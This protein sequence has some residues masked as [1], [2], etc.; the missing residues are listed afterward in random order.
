MKFAHFLSFLM[1]LCSG[2]FAQLPVSTPE[3]DLSVVEDLYLAKD[4]GNGKPGDVVDGFNTYD[5]PIHCVVNLA[6]SEPIAVKMNLVAVKV[7]GVRPETKVV[8]TGYT[9]KEK[10]NR[11]NFSGRPDGFWVAG[12][13]RVDIFV[14][15]KLEKSLTFVIMKSS[16]SEGSM[17]FTP[18]KPKPGK[19]L[20]TN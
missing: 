6:T 1:L 9:T 14:A 8:T 11:V 16:G 5:I 18:S 17:K 3:A 20:K 13:Y 4:D 19:P 10:Q 15:G 7:A 12:T 2:A